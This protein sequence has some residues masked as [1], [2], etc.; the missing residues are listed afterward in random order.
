MNDAAI[1]EDLLFMDT[2]RGKDATGI[3]HFGGDGGIRVIK[4]SVPAYA[5]TYN[6]EY[7]DIIKDFIRTARQS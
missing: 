4:E 6:T 2:L 3:A 5:F 7:N 1:F